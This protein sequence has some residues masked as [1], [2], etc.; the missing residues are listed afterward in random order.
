[1]SGKGGHSGGGGGGAKG[2]GGGGSHAS[3]DARSAAFNP[4]ASSSIKAV[5]WRG[6]GTLVEVRTNVSALAPN[7]SAFRLPYTPTAQKTLTRHH[8][9]CSIFAGAC[10]QPN[11]CL[12]GQCNGLQVAGQHG[13]P[14]H[15][16][17]SAVLR[18]QPY[19]REEVERK[20]KI[21]GKRGLKGR[22]CCRSK[23]PP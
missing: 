16:D 13:C 21:K 14:L 9:L 11:R 20:A 2:G 8:L 10:L 6:L 12:C 18:I 19:G 22:E 5:V 3:N 7:V 1:M 4:Q 17:E 15:G 23:R